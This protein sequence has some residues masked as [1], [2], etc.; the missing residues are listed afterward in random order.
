MALYAIGFIF[1]QVK[2]ITLP[3][4]E[5][6]KFLS[7]SFT[8]RNHHR[9]FLIFKVHFISFHSEIPLHTI[10]ALSINKITEKREQ[11][12]DI[13]TMKFKLKS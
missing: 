5:I 13:C 3:V 2:F 1:N 11:C 9:K 4:L 8:L 12:T 6:S 7:T 10:V